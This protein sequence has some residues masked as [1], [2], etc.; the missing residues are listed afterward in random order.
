MHDHRPRAWYAVPLEQ[1]RLIDLVAAAH[2][3]L[4]VVDHDD[5]L[6]RR[7]CGRLVRVVVHPSRLTNKQ[8]VVL[9][10]TTQIAAPYQRTAHIELARRTNETPQRIGVGRRI[11]FVRIDQDCKFVPGRM[12]RRQRRPREEAL[13]S[14]DHKV[15]MRLRD[16]A[17]RDQPHTGKLPA[18]RIPETRT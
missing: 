12:P 13:G 9:G 17:E 14:L 18:I 1:L 4:R 11:D 3:R 8:S 6:G 10:Q 7:A 15:M 2:D 16:I 5:P